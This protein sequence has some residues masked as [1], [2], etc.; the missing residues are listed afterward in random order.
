[1][2][3]QSVM[4]IYNDGVISV[5]SKVNIGSFRCVC[6]RFLFIRQMITEEEKEDLTIKVREKKM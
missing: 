4:S 2:C 1:M 3:Q 6:V 5:W